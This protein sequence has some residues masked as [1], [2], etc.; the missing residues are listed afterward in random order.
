MLEQWKMD[1]DVIEMVEPLYCED[2][3]IPNIDPVALFEMVL[4]QHLYGY[5]HPFGERR[6]L[7]I[8]SQ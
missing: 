7:Q 6:S 5:C 8:K 4:I 3:A 2:T 1:R